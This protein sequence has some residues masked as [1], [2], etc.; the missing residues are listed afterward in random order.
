MLSS[1]FHHTN[2]TALKKR[3]FFPKTLFLFQFFVLVYDFLG[4]L[5]RSTLYPYFVIVES[6]LIM[7]T[8][9]HK[10]FFIFRAF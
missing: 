1:T 7:S 5:Y 8:I 4:V 3:L 9:T 2:T 6:S 10:A